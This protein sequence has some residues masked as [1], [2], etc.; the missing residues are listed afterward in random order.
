MNRIVSMS[1]W[2]CAPQGLVQR[3]PM[4]DA[5]FETNCC[6]LHAARNFL[7]HTARGAALVVSSF[8][9]SAGIFGLSTSEAKGGIVMSME[10]DPAAQQRGANMSGFYQGPGQGGSMHVLLEY[11]GDNGRETKFGG[12]A[13]AFN[14]YGLIATGH[15]FY[16]FLGRNLTIK[17]GD[18]TN[19]M[20]NPGTFHDISEIFIHPGYEGPDTR[21][22]NPD[23]AVLRYASP[24]Q[25]YADMLFADMRSP[26]DSALS[27]AGF[28]RPGSVFGGYVDRDGNARGG[29]SYVSSF[30]P[31]EGES[32]ELYFRTTMLLMN[33]NEL[34]PAVGDSGSP[35]Y[36]SDGE[37]LGM[38]TRAGTSTLSGYG[39]ALDLTRPE[40]HSYINTILAPSS[41]PEPGAILLMGAG[42]G[43]FGALSRLRRA[44][45]R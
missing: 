37:L 23:I 8:L 34:R 29:E 26:T 5:E 41:V 31:L 10:F 33:S 36:N 43:T 28:G 12:T 15:Q 38:Y 13:I 18:G 42:V 9:G 44:K 45:K 40:M 20:T 16:E 4:V 39:L 24:V 14:R 2:R 35:L 17:V 25:Q 30:G 27:W 1:P 32:P 11:D 21:F 19:Y 6:T 7:R 22:T 3:M